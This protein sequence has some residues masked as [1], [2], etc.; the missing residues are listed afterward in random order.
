[1]NLFA[2]AWRNVFRNR[3]RSFIT[4]TAIAV[5]TAAVM[6]FGGYVVGMVLNIE[7]SFVQATG[8]L[9]L[10]KKGYSDEGQADP[11]A[12]SMD[13]YQNVL[14]TFRQDPYFR[15]RAVVITP[16]LR[17]SGI[18][19][20][21][22]EESSVTFFGKGVVPE[23]RERMKKWNPYHM[24][25]PPG[26]DNEPPLDAS[27]S[28]AGLIGRSMARNLSLCDELKV[29]DCQ[30]RE[31]Q[32][33]LAKEETLTDAPP[34]EDLGFLEEV[35]QQDSPAAPQEGELEDLSFLEEV[36]DQQQNVPKKSAA[37]GEATLDLMAATA[38]G[39]AN[40]VGLKVRGTADFG[41]RMADN[42]FIVMHLDHA[43]QLVFG[44]GEK[45]ITSIAIQLKKSS[46]MNTA[47]ARAE[48]L[49]KKHGWDIEV[50]DLPVIAPLYVQV[51]GMMGTIFSFMAIIMGA[52]VVFTVANTMR[53]SVMERVGEIGTLRS[54]GLRQAGVRR[55]FIVEGAMLGIVGATA[56]VGLAA[57]A[58]V[59]FNAIGLTWTPPMRVTPV[60]IFV[61]LFENPLLAPGVW[62]VLAGAATLSS[63]A[64]ARAAAR[65][66]VVDALRQN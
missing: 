21:F 7:T 30:D 4:M 20:N 43:Q 40:V 32:A 56:G 19:G 12:Y 37:T 22:K 60:Y 29:R 6:L 53:M 2:L 11:L 14:R 64:P 8:H 25:M 45:K 28:E 41:E 16:T 62:L 15:Q 39:S 33:A 10:Y 66:A 17:A 50:Q 24:A 42:H 57:L 54:M 35:Q 46:Y 36:K 31:K 18:V 58:G 34:L 61:K 65:M 23:H 13:D 52:I 1:M 49:V 59:V 3:R 26:S 55:L 48:A 44:R 63:L 27:D 5:G 38:G 9:H 51:L 47:K